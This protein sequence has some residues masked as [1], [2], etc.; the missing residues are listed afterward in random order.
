MR[1]PQTATIARSQTRSQPIRVVATA[2][3]DHAGRPAFCY[4][5]NTDGPTPPRFSFQVYIIGDISVPN[6][7]VGLASDCGGA[8]RLDVYEPQPDIWACIEHQRLERKWRKW[9]DGF[10][11]KIPKHYT[12]QVAM[13]AHIVVIDRPD[14]YWQN[15]DDDNTYHGPLEVS[16]NPWDEE[17]KRIMVDGTNPDWA[18]NEQIELQV[19]RMRTPSFPNRTLKRL[20]ADSYT[21]FDESFEFGESEAEAK[22]EIKIKIATEAESY[23]PPAPLIGARITLSGLGVDLQTGGDPELVYVVYPQ[24][25]TT[26]PVDLTRIAHRFAAHLKSPSVRVVVAPQLA[27]MRECVAYA[28]ASNIRVGYV[29]S[30]YGRRFPEYAAGPGSYRMQNPV[31]GKKLFLILLDRVEWER[32]D[33][34]CFLWIGEGDKILLGR[35]AGGM[36]RVAARLGDT[37]DFL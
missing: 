27:G 37:S 19:E 30:P 13:A 2:F 24:F 5:H 26:T 11:G 17:E 7:F 3:P 28:A 8:W 31:C 14:W 10:P 33:G 20:C 36:G 16:F 1:T 6:P 12:D 15:N 29:R 34:V 22:P 9:H 25:A 18:M 35:V 21:W 4:F 23:S 32:E